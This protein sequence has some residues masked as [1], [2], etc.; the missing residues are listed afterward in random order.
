M[1]TILLIGAAYMFVQYGVFA[2]LRSLLGDPVTTS[3][4]AL[5]LLLTGMAFGSSRSDAVAQLPRWKRAAL[6]STGPVVGALLLA[7]LP[8]G[9]GTRAWLLRSGYVAAAM[10]PLGASLGLFFPLGLR[11][12]PAAAVPTAFLFDA[13]G[14]ALGFFAFLLVALSGG[15]AAGLAVGAALYALAWLTRE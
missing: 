15:I 1:P 5:L 8:E 10:L 11:G 3:Y 7:A 2:R 4:T 13:L 6:A 9:L 12:R 14:A